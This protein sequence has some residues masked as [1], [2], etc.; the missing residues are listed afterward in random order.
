MKSKDRDK[1]KSKVIKAKP[2]PFPRRVPSWVIDIPVSP[3]GPPGPTGA[4]G[5]T[6]FGLEAFA[7][8]YNTDD[9]TV[10]AE[11]DILFSDNGVIVGGITHTP[12]EAEITVTEAGFYEITFSVSAVMQNQFTIFVNDTEVPETIYGSGA[13]EQ[14]NDGQVILELAAGDVITLRNHTSQTGDV[15]LENDAG[16]TQTNVSASIIIKKLD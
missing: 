5:A 13:G 10:G 9:Q 8:I 16:G 15:N 14:Q 4:T 1:C 7:Y 6:G 12:G 2:E 11:E 3:T